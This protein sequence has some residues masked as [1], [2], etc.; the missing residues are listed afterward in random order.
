MVATIP[1]LQ[2]TFAESITNVLL[3]TANQL[4]SRRLQ[5]LFALSKGA[6]KNIFLAATALCTTSDFIGTATRTTFNQT[7]WTSLFKPLSKPTRMNA[8]FGRSVRTT[9]D[10]QEVTQF[11]AYLN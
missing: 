3:G 5:F 10:T 2:K 8:L 1:F 11:V 4:K 9:D 6:E 7:S